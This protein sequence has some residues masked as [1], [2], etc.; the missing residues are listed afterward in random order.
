MHN[1]EA[2]GAS[3]W[4]RLVFH[5]H[6]RKAL[7]QR[8]ETATKLGMWPV[9]THAVEIG[10]WVWVVA[11]RLAVGIRRTRLHLDVGGGEGELIEAE[12]VVRCQ[13]M[14]QLRRG[15]LLLEK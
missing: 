15:R 9:K 11:G 13:G 5:L 6:M 8:P 3:A 4:P 2:T 12:V 7:N 10:V 14:A 1:A